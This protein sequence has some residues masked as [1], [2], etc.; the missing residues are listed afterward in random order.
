MVC[1]SFT[2][3]VFSFEF[4]FAS[5]FT[6]TMHLS[7]PATHLCAVDNIIR[8]PLW[9]QN[10]VRI[11][12]LPTSIF[13]IARIQ[14]VLMG[15]PPN[16]NFDTSP[17][18]HIFVIFPTIFVIFP[19][20]S[21]Y[22]NPAFL[23]AM[24]LQTNKPI[25]DKTTKVTKMPS[26]NSPSQLSK[27]SKGLGVPL[28]PWEVDILGPNYYGMFAVL[29]KMC[30]WWS[31]GWFHGSIRASFEESCHKLITFFD[32]WVNS[33]IKRSCILRLLMGQLWHHPDK[34]LKRVKKRSRG[35]SPCSTPPT[36]CFLFGP[37]IC[38]RYWEL[39]PPPWRPPT[40][41]RVQETW[42]ITIGIGEGGH[43]EGI[44]QVKKQSPQP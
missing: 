26:E 28:M 9:L 38:S 7:Q 35:K 24:E 3:D 44:G 17:T 1:Q 20:W 6:T 27:L 30:F 11:S 14:R 19:A 43:V 34:C 2:N 37:P 12:P 40:P 4:N 41:P 39:Y 18:N 21:S 25:C 22:Q 42:F 36:W 32:V 5:A 15:I 29:P 31:L 23:A 10:F 8:R 33:T 13:Q 16:L